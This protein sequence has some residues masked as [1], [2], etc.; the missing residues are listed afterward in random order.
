MS[1]ASIRALIERYA[2][3]W[4]RGDVA[5]CVACYHDDF[6]LHYFG[7]NALTGN[8]VGKA[9]SLAT[10]RKVAERTHW[11]VVAIKSTL[12]GADRGAIVARVAYGAPGKVEER[13]RVLVFAVKNDLLLE[14]WAYDEDPQLLDELIGR[15]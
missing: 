14:C 8:H 3:A 15:A 1:E 10:L 6:T 13:D 5:A 9:A 12:A 4:L 2:A 11:R 7:R